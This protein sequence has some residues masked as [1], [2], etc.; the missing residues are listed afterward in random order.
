MI[1]GLDVST[2]IVGFT[3]LDDEGNIIV[4]EAWDLRKIKNL[5]MVLNILGRIRRK[6]ENFKQKKKERS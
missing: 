4:N 2:S 6:T 1:Y 5:F 3:V